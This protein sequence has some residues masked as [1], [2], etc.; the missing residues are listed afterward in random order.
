MGEVHYD[1]E[2]FYHTEGTNYGDNHY[3]GNPIE[4]VHV[5]S[6]FEKIKRDQA[7]LQP[8]KQGTPDAAMNAD[9]LVQK[10]K[11][12]E[13]QGNYKEYNRISD[14]LHQGGYPEGNFV[15]E[16]VPF[17]QFTAN[18][19]WYEVTD[20]RW[21]KHQRSDSAM[22]QTP[23]TPDAA[24][25]AKT[26]IEAWKLTGNVDKIATMLGDEDASVRQS[27]EAALIKLGA[28]RERMVDGYIAA[29][30]SE[31][32]KARNNA[33]EKLGDLGDKRAIEQLMR[34]WKYFGFRIIEEAL[35]KL[36][37]SK[38]QMFPLYISELYKNSRYVAKKLGDLGDKRAIGPLLELLSYDLKEPF[39]TSGYATFPYND[40]AEQIR[41]VIIMVLSSLV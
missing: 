7:M 30:S 26:R 21:E 33:A 10:M 22:L 5:P 16:E 39:Y 34:R 35:E 20:Y 40:W 4:S 25:F 11:E 32:L 31:Y 15:Y 24:M 6:H 12:A 23:Q 1:P 9:E 37:A 29:L 19:P 8:P 27:A 3:G 14:L 13:S 2:Y 28:S 38:E 18:G 36:G 41:F 17:K